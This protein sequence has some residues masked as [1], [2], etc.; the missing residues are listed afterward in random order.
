MRQTVA[1]L[2]AAS[3][4]FS[5]SAWV[6]SSPVPAN[7][8]NLLSQRYINSILDS[9]DEICSQN[10]PKQTLR[11]VLTAEVTSGIRAVDCTRPRCNNMKL[12]H[13][14]LTWIR[15]MA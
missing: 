5:R 8:S 10:I 15:Q 13:A 6:P 12:T 14:V 3:R 9:T 11:A 2:T 1:G 4:S 7:N